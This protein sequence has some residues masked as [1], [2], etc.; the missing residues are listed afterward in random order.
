MIPLHPQFE[1][2]D[3]RVFMTEFR[4]LK[5]PC[6]VWIA[7]IPAIEISLIC[8]GN[9]TAPP[10]GGAVGTCELP[11]GRVARCENRRYDNH[12]DASQDAAHPMV[13][14]WRRFFHRISS[15]LPCG[16]IGGRQKPRCHGAF[17]FAPAVILTCMRLFGRGRRR[18]AENLCGKWNRPTFRRGGGYLRTTRRASCTLRES[19]L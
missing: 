15:F 6:F 18:E 9:G 1:I 10:F 14:P 19:P 12:G 2:D 8:A 3:G 4:L 13:S 7:G 11:D 16:W 17:S 5:S